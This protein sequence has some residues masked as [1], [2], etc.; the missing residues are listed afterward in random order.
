MTHFNFSLTSQSHKT[1]VL[2]IVFKNKK[3]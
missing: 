1:T 3:S 2:R